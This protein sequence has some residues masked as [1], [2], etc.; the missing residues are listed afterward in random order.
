M[1]IRM[2]SHYIDMEFRDLENMLVLVD[3]R[4]GKDLDCWKVHT[5]GARATRWEL[6][7]AALKFRQSLILCGVV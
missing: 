6:E 3:F 1:G 5:A 2:P 7:Y 4:N